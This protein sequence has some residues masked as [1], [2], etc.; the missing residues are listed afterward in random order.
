MDDL[1]QNQEIE[2]AEYRRMFSLRLIPGLFAPF[3]F[4][5]V[6]FVFI[7]AVISGKHVGRQEMVFVPAG[8]L[9]LIVGS[10]FGLRKW[11]GYDYC[12]R[13]DASGLTVHGAGR[14][15]FLSWSEIRVAKTTYVDCRLGVRHLLRTDSVRAAV[16]L[17]AEEVA[18]S[19]KYHLSRDGKGEDLEV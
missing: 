11:P 17:E 16:P 15:V 6:L 12:W 3:L 10:V 19:I 2:S 9:L 14:R 4:S 1:Q 7:G 18:R 5:A 8:C 13:A